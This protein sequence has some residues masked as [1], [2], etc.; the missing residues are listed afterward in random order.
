MIAIVCCGILSISITPI[1]DL[2]AQ[3][4]SIPSSTSTPFS[5]YSNPSYNFE[6]NYPT[7]WDK[8]EPEA[9]PDIRAVDVVG[10]SSPLEDS[11]DEWYEAFDV[12]YDEIPYEADLADYIEESI[13][14]YET[15][16]N[17]EIVSQNTYSL[18]SGLPAYEIVYTYTYEEE[19][20]DDIEIK[21]Y[22]I[23][24]ILNN[25][26][27][28]YINFQSKESEYDT[29]FPL[30]KQSVNSF[31][32]GKVGEER[33][34][35]PQPQSQSPSPS[36]LPLGS[37]PGRNFISYSNSDIGIN[38]LTYPETYELID[39]SKEPGFTT[40]LYNTTVLLEIVSP[41][42]SG[43]DD[44]QEY[45]QIGVFENID[46]LTREDS[47]AF[48]EGYLST[49]SDKQ[50]YELVESKYSDLIDGF[51]TYKAT[52]KTFDSE[53]Q[54]PLQVT[55]YAVPAGEKLYWIKSIANPQ[56]VNKYL[57]V[58][59]T[60][61]NSL[62]LA[63]PKSSTSV[64]DSR[65]PNPGISNAKYIELALDEWRSDNIDVIV[66]VNEDSQNQSSKYV[67]IVTKAVHEWS[68]LLKQYSN[69]SQAWNFNVRSEVGNLETVQPS[70]PNTI[71]L[72]LVSTPLDY[73]FC[74]DMLGFASPHPEAVNKPVMATVL[75]SCSDG[76]NI[77]DLP[78]E[79]V[80]ST[81]IHEFAHTLGLG[82]AF[83]IAYDLMCSYDWYPNGEEKETC[84]NY[85]TTGKI[86]PSENDILALLYKY[87]ND[88]FSLPNRDLFGEGG[89]L[90]P[91]FKIADD[92]AN[93]TTSNVQ[94]GLTFR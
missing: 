16:K 68:D 53:L 42:V 29:Y 64:G 27:G 71:I 92:V 87:G 37:E 21:A 58:F 74:D 33:I 48:V 80:Y 38:N 6:I 45:L 89:G 25:S 10:F 41:L 23:G 78:Q 73:N 49:E 56:Q 32:I 24:T 77:L 1:N 79:D 11:R 12:Y 62:D 47:K 4:Q 60:I 57:P 34:S 69:N 67:N 39:Y 35:T 86:Q 28:Y 93:N 30:V 91:V 70:N 9:N 3:A 40:G 63:G 66:L 31:K 88:G 81:A 36:P 15:N 84:I 5:T 90:R 20:L 2:L 85:E 76:F 65:S 94:A 55:M 8:I 19:G 22:E 18:L 50:S 26:Q 13:D 59:D 83:N 43:L 44:Q 52:F 17:F 82:H 7:N 75:T 61:L 46:S 72:E 54:V 14:V 51:D